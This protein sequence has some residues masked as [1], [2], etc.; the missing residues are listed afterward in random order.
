MR[1]LIGF[2]SLEVGGEFI[3]YFVL[4]MAKNLNLNSLLAP[5]VLPSRGVLVNYITTEESH[6]SA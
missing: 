5:A 3:I 1:D 6:L 2:I 4:V